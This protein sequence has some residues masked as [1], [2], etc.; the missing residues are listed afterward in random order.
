MV[1]HSPVTDSGDLLHMI[2][3][4]CTRK[5]SRS[6]A[7]FPLS[8]PRRHRAPSVTETILEGQGNGG[9]TGQK[10]SVRVRATPC[11]EDKDA[12]KAPEKQDRE[13]EHKIGD[14]SSR[15]Q[16]KTL[17]D[18]PL[19]IQGLILDYLF[20][21]LHSVTS[22]STSLQSGGTRVSSAMRHPRRKALTDV[23]LVSP[24][25]RELVQERIY[26]HSKNGNS[27]CLRV[28]N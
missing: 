2:T 11:W 8:T 14:S 20:G 13:M 9:S 17:E 5:L 1:H 12:S 10:L 25:W 24:T 15:R 3:P 18:L 23:A 16:R 6:D 21:D 4:G 19:E 26:R 22:T 7:H 28:E 27:A